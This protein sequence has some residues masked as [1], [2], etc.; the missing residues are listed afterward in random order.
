MCIILFCNNI[1][2]FFVSSNILDNF[3]TDFALWAGSIIESPYPYVCVSVIKV[4]IVNNCQSIMF[5]VFLYKTVWACMVLRILYLER[6]QSCMIG[7]KFTT[8]LTTFLSIINWG[9]FFIL[10]QSTPYNG[11][12]SRVSSVIVGI[13]EGARW[14]VTCDVSHKIRDSWNVQQNKKNAKKTARNFLKGGIS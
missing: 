5:S 1:T 3:F 8:S 12:V 2:V 7:Y 11:G 9:L 6:H 10:N 13:S 4:V 14:N